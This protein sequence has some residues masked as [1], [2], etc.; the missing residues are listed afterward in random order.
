MRDELVEPIEEPKKA[1]ARFRGASQRV[2]VPRNVLVRGAAEN[3]LDQAILASKVFVE[4]PAGDV[5]FFEQRVHSNQGALGVEEALSC[6]EKSF[7]GSRGGL[8]T[9]ERIA[10]LKCLTV[11]RL[12]YILRDRLIVLLSKRLKCPN[13][14]RRLL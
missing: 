6:R 5:R 14:I 13:P 1:G 8:G 7:P 9:H 10:I 2:L 12:V 4:R 3:R 11:E